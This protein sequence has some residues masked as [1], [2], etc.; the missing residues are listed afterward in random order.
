MALR[1]TEGLGVARCCCLNAKLESYWC[2]RRFRAVRPMS[3][4]SY[5]PEARCSLWRVT[6]TLAVRMNFAD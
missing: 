3:E 5:L 6:P 4:R 2:G 1:L